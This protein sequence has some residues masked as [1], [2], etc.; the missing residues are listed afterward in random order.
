MCCSRENFEEVG[1]ASYP[2]RVILT[3]PRVQTRIELNYKD[4]AVNEPADLTLYEMTAPANVP[5][6]EVDE[7]GNP[8]EG[9]PR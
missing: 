4:V 3:A 8:R 9:A 5:I 1:P 7:L 6:V 2:R